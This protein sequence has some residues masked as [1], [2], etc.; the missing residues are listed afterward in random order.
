[1]LASTLWIWIFM[2]KITT[3][4]TPIQRVADSKWMHIYTALFHCS[5]STTPA[6][7]W[8]PP[9]RTDCHHQSRQFMNGRVS[10]PIN[11]GVWLKYWF[12]SWPQ[13][14]C[15]KLYLHSLP[16]GPVLSRSGRPAH[17][18]AKR[19]LHCG[20]LHFSICDC[21][22]QSRLQHHRGTLTKLRVQS[23]SATW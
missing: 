8:S 21:G 20:G 6:T 1:M 16:E 2:Q 9:F 4:T 19:E 7:H 10:N 14:D 13:L 23:N 15:N 18:P 22:V 3:T 11:Q 5:S 12:Y 17:H